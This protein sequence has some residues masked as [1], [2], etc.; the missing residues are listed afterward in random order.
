MLI[1][2]MMPIVQRRLVSIQEDASLMAAAKLLAEGHINIVVIVASGGTMSGVLT[3][4]DI[5]RQM[6][7]CRGSSCTVPVSSVMTRDVTSC[8][9]T[10]WLQDVWTSMTATGL[11]QFP[12]LGSRGEPLGVLYARDALQALLGEVRD[13]EQLLKDYVM[14]MGYR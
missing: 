4:T 6:G 13:E 8:F 11:L 9:T 10:D 14:S 1:E 3:K 12:V 2:R 7:S 5:V